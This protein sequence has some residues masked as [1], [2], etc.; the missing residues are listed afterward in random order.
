MVNFFRNTLDGPLYVIVAIL[1]LIFIMAIIGFL[2][3]R[4]KLEKEE[5]DKIAYINSNGVSQF[6][7][8]NVEENSSE[9]VVEEAFTPLTDNIVVNN[10][11]ENSEMSEE[12]E[13]DRP[14]EINIFKNLEE[15]NQNNDTMNVDSDGIPVF[16]PTANE[17][18][19]AKTPVI[20]F[21]D[22]DLKNEKK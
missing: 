10:N 5:K 15:D 17:V 16:N 4:K 1:A 14:L 22:P 8:V 12:S 3:E 7:N 11:L 19:D 2:M 20:L 21:E 13:E 9:P 6:E 18:T